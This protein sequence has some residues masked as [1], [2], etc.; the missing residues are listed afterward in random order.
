LSAASFM[1]V[2]GMV[3]KTCSRRCGARWDDSSCRRSTRT[4]SRTA[5]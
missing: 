2:A 4:G 5:W 3:M 1:G